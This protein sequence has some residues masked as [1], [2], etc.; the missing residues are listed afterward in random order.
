MEF[1]ILVLFQQNYG[2][3]NDEK[4]TGR[5]FHTSIIQKQDLY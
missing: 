5:Q 1:Y 2:I 4:W 3:L